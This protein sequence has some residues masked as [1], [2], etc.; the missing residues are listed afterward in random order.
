MKT[1]SLLKTLCLAAAFAALGGVAAW[2]T[3]VQASALESGEIATKISVYEKASVRKSDPSGIRFIGT[4][5]KTYY[6]SVKDTAEFGGK[7]TFTYGGTN[8][9][10]EQAITDDELI[11]D[12]GDEMYYQIAITDLPLDSYNVKFK[13]QSYVKETSEAT[14]V[15]SE[16]YAERSIGYVAGKANADDEAAVIDDIINVASVN[17]ALTASRVDLNLSDAT[18]KTVSVKGTTVEEVSYEIADTN[19]ATVAADGKITAVGVGSTTLTATVGENEKTCQINVSNVTA[20]EYELTVDEEHKVANTLDISNLMAE[21][22]AGVTV[23]KYEQVIKGVSTEL[24]MGENNVVSGVQAGEGQFVLTDTAGTKYVANTSVYTLKISTAAELLQMSKILEKN[25]VNSGEFTEGSTTYTGYTSGGYF[26]LEN[27]ITYT[28]TW[29]SVFTVVKTYKQTTVGFNGTFDGRGYMIDILIGRYS[30]ATNG[31]LFGAIAAGGVVKNLH[32]DVKWADNG[33]TYNH[34][35]FGYVIAGTLQDISLTLTSQGSQIGS[36]GILSGGITE[37]A[38]LERI[39]IRT[40]VT[41][42]G[43]SN[44]GW[45]T[46]YF[47]RACT[48][49]HIYVIHK[50][51]GYETTGKLQFPFTFI[52]T[53]NRQKHTT[54]SLE[55]YGVI[56]GAY[57]ASEED[58]ASRTQTIVSNRQSATAEDYNWKTSTDYYKSDVTTSQYNIDYSEFDSSIWTFNGIYPEVDNQLGENE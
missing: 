14:K 34:G 7:V 15:Y 18:T 9:T 24:T 47:D 46:A 26:V 11:L 29:K 57:F 8:H 55:R 28:G 56:C 54:N 20:K 41:A 10:Y 1:K 39:V 22:P 32:L 40:D 25:K 43:S 49:K 13:M 44:S 33:L 17:F 37:T 42:N 2:N 38:V 23:A 35:V 45:L 36:G 4:I 48:M 53:V 16:A 30:E 52:T 51:D 19:V 21:I 58:F 3:D 50:D 6:E 31:G 5:D 12:G 27:D